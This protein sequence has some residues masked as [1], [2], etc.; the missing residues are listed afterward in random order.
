MHGK[1]RM[2]LALLIVVAVAVVAAGIAAY[3]VIRRKIE[4]RDLV[5]LEENAEWKQ[6]GELRGGAQDVTVRFQYTEGPLELE[7]RPEHLIG[8]EWTQGE[9][10]SLHLAEEKLCSLPEAQKHRFMA[11]AVRLPDEDREFV[12]GEVRILLTPVQ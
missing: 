3:P 11:Q 12:N 6:V 8:G 4:D 7:I 10:F 1:K 5:W 2:K 9:I